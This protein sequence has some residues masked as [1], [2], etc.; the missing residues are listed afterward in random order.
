[1]VVVMFAVRAGEPSAS[2]SGTTTWDA[3]IGEQYGT[4]GV[5]P[6]TCCGGHGPARACDNA[7]CSQGGARFARVPRFIHEGEA[8]SVSAEA[9]G[10]VV[11]RGRIR[12]GAV[13][14]VGLTLLCAVSSSAGAQSAPWTV[15]S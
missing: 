1:M 10:G 11:M 2:R 14:L 12:I 15:Q 8:S 13:G 9:G 6:L 5:A 3:G 4:T 7:N